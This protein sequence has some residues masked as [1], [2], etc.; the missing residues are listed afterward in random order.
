MQD[1][2]QDKQKVTLY[3]SPEL[4][5]QLKIRAAVDGEPMS[6][7]AER[8]IAFF[9]Q[10]SD[11]IEATEAIQGKVHRILECPECAASL[12]FRESELAVIGSHSAFLTD[13]NLTPEAVRHS[14]AEPGSDSQPAHSLVTC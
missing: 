11:V 8:A 12:V 10:Y 4:H 6:S 9:L 7:I 14:T 3:F 2:H 5:Q 13:E 1:K